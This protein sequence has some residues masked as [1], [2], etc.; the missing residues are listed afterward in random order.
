MKLAV[1]R[2]TYYSH[3]SKAGDVGRQLAFAGIAVVWIL[4]GR[5]DAWVFPPSLLWTLA[6]FGVYLVADFLQYA[7]AS[8]VWGLYGWR[9]ERG[10]DKAGLEPSQQEFKAPDQINIPA[11]VMFCLKSAVLLIGGILLLVY[12]GGRIAAVVS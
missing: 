7:I 8:A 5:S 6:S 3:T 9:K 10:F 11:L 4:H 12:V 2:D 1:V